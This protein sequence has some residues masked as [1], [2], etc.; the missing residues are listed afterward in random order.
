[1][2]LLYGVVILFDKLVDMG[3]LKLECVMFK[4]LNKSCCDIVG[5]GLLVMFCKVSWVSVVL[6]FE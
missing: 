5:K 2:F 3:C 1:M 6:L 4:G